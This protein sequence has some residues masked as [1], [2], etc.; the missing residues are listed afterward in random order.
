MRKLLHD[1]KKKIQDS[2]YFYFYYIGSQKLCDKHLATIAK[3][4]DILENPNHHKKLKRLNARKSSTSSA[5]SASS[6][7]SNISNA[8]H[9]NENKENKNNYSDTMSITTTNTAQPYQPHFDNIPIDCKLEIMRRLNCG[10]DLIN[11]SKCN[12]NL[13]DLISNELKIWKN[14]CQFHFQQTNINSF[15]N[16]LQSTTATTTSSSKSAVKVDE[17]N[18]FAN[19]NL[20]WKQIYFRLK[21]RY[22][23]REVYVDM[24]H[25]CYHCKSLFWKVKFAQKLCVFYFFT[26]KYGNVP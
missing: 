3:W 23:H 13:N 7:S 26:G 9:N 8:N 22:G 2:I 6:A 4:Q 16:R 18:L 24:V 11:L 15:V 21:R 5:S 1:F 14:L 10:L 17:A 20:D 25:K 12:R 19:D